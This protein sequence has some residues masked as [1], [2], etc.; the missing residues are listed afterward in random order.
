MTLTQDQP[1]TA[2]CDSSFGVNLDLTVTDRETAAELLRY[3]E[4]P[5]REEFALSALKV[6]VL[7][8][9]QASGVCSFAF[10]T[11]ATGLTINR[12]VF[13]HQLQ[14]VTRAPR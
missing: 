9:R 4:V 6:G 2:S 3:R 10:A 12:S 11:S 5:A 8:I 14:N 1:M 13:T 7:A